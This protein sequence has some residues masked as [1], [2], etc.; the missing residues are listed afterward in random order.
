M[1]SEEKCLNPFEESGSL[2]N[3][4]EDDLNESFDSSN[5]F[6]EK[7]ST[8]NVSMDSSNMNPFEDDDKPVVE[9]SPFASHKVFPEVQKSKAKH[10]KS[11]TSSC[12]FQEQEQL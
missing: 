8:E 12:C 5:P 9:E 10:N 6:L 2:Q 11:E 7:D 3:P 4:F 1:Y